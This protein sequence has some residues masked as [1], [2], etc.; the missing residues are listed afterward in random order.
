MTKIDLIALVAALT[1]EETKELLRL[2]V[3][4]LK[5]GDILDEILKNERMAEFIYNAL[6]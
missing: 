6:Y 4:V 1:E 2:C 3:D 5:P